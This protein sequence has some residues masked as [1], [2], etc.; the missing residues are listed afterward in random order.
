MQSIMNVYACPS[1]QYELT[2]D[3]YFLSVSILNVLN[4]ILSGRGAITYKPFSERSPVS[5]SLSSSADFTFRPELS[6]S[7]PPFLN[8]AAEG[9]P[10]FASPPKKI[11]RR[12]AF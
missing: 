12:F 5:E 1:K 7:L 3:I 10:V 6:P 11:F 4:F 9:S 8:L 2:K